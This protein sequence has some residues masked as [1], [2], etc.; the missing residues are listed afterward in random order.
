[1]GALPMAGKRH[2][3]SSLL[4]VLNNSF[5][6]SPCA[7]YFDSGYINSVREMGLFFAEIPTKA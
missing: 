2:E 1:M 4:D 5:Y 6:I 3:S 7:Y